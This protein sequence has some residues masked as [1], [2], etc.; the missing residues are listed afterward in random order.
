MDY[1]DLKREHLLLPSVTIKELKEDVPQL[2]TNAKWQAFIECSKWNISRGLVR[3]KDIV[4][5]D[6]AHKL[7]SYKK[8]KDEVQSAYYA[9]YRMSGTIKTRRLLEKQWLK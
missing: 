3:E 4:V 2:G 9:K 8:E 1:S 5:L 6:G 7:L